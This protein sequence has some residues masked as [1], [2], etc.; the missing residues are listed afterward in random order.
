MALKDAD[1]RHVEDA[2]VNR[3]ALVNVQYPTFNYERL[4]NKASTMRRVLD[5]DNKSPTY[6]QPI[7]TYMRLYYK[8]K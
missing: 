6:G 1:M 7:E 3:Y 5:D 8:R 2:T 4:A